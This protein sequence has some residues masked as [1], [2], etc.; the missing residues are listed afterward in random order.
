MCRLPR[1][2]V[3]GFEA[4]YAL[5]TTVIFRLFGWLADLE[6][7]VP[8]AILAFA[9]AGAASGWSAQR[10]PVLL[11]AMRRREIALIRLWGRW[12]LPVIACLFLFAMSAG[13]W[14]GHVRS[15][16][17]NY[18]SIAGLVPNSDALSY[19]A[20]AGALAFADGHWGI[21]SSRRP[22]AQAFRQI[23]VSL[24]QYSYLATLF[25]QAGMLA[26]LLF[27]AARRIA[28]WRGI[29]AGIAFFGFVFLLHRPYLNTTMTEPLGLA[30]A[31]LA[32]VHLIEALRRTRCRTR[33]SRWS[34]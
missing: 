10:D 9:A 19:F 1:D 5:P 33:W 12:G 16:D 23:T 7:L 4:G 27:W 17:F 31:L 14:S 29:W 28:L 15:A 11:R 6:P 8:Y 18:N 21:V 25:I 13:G 20:D 3:Y 26:V 34:R 30:C 32:L 24:A 2:V 22:L